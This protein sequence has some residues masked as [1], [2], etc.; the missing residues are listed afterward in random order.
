[1]A[2]KRRDL[3]TGRLF[4]YFAWIA[5]AGILYVLVDYMVDLR[6]ASI[7]ASYQFRLPVLE[8][9]KPVILRQ[10]NL[11][12]VVLARSGALIDALRN[13]TGRLQDPESRDSH[14]PGFAAN[15]VRSR[16]PE[17]FV[18]Y[19]LGTDLGCALIVIDGGLGEACGPARY[20]FAGRAIRGARE[21]QNLAIPD[22]NFSDNFQ[23]L[24][25]RP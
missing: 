1:M 8:P 24:T 21:F 3:F 25:I 10:D 4:R 9:D 19:A 22:Y 7:A 6:P 5:G 11:S 13:E 20:D 14:Q 17:F 18:A 15:P 16:D 12:I 23:T 2:A